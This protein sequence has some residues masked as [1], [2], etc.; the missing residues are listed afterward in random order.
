MLQPVNRM[1]WQHRP[2]PGES[3]STGTVADS[4]VMHGKSTFGRKLML[5]C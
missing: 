3:C 4:K 1:T 2:L 5:M